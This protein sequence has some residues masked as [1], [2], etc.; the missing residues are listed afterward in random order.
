MDYY[1]Y[2]YDPNNIVL[3]FPTPL[4]VAYLLSG[5]LYNY[6]SK[7]KSYRFLL[8]IGIIITNISLF[9]LFL[10]SIIFKNSIQTGFV[11]SLVT[12][13][14]IGFASN[15]AQLTFFAMINYLGTVVVSRFT[16]GTAISGLMLVVLRMIIVAILG[17]DE[18]N[19]LPIWIYMVL[20]ILF[21]FFNLVLNIKF[22]ASS[23]Y[24]EQV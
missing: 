7:V 24:K 5:I 2:I 22:F 21:N 18:S 13:F 1:S 14:I 4:F 11:L 10:L 3:W 8:T 6:M 9:V 17:S 12:C 20:A 23:D 16:I 19:T 15:T